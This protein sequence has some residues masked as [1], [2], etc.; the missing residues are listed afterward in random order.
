MSFLKKIRSYCVY[1]LVMGLQKYKVIVYRHVYSDNIANLKGTAVNQ[2]LRTC[3]KGII[4]VVGC[5]VGVY[6]S[7][8]FM[9]GSS[10][11]EAREDG[12]LIIIG[13]GTFINNSVTIISKAGKISIGRNCLIGSNVFITNSDFHGLSKLDRVNRVVISKD[14]E[15]GDDVFIGSNALILK[16]V[17][18]GVGA[19][20][21][22]GAVIST[23]VPPNALYAGNPG[24]LV[25]FIEN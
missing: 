16:G 6:R 12:A 3:G 2:P 20:I 14:V 13:K 7:P 8:H 17:T 18:V 4:N 22:A 25:K 5:E 23:D 19:I 21:G 15:I 11:F 24:R 9:C 10:Y 1:L